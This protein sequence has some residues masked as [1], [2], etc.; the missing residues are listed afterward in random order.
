MMPHGRTRQLGIVVGLEATSVFLENPQ[1]ICAFLYLSLRRDKQSANYSQ[2]KA[3]TNSTHTTPKGQC[4]K[5][6]GTY[7]EGQAT[8]LS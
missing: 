2:G 4:I 6:H 5:G 1:E 3:L 7:K 8:T